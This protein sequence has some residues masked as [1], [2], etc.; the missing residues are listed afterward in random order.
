MQ[1]VQLEAPRMEDPELGH[2]LIGM[3]RK[4]PVYGGL[5][6]T[7][8]DP[9]V[10]GH[11]E[12]RTGAGA[13]APF[14]FVSLEYVFARARSILEMAHHG[15]LDDDVTREQV[16]LEFR[17]QR[18]LAEQG[19]HF[20]VLDFEVSVA[21]DRRRSITGPASATTSARIGGGPTDGAGSPEASRANAPGLAQ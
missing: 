10:I 3:I 5:G 1:V 9:V 15:L 21:N 17:S 4:W 13:G 8:E 20:D 11:P 16:V 6:Y 18:L 7:R 12:P 19:K 2:R 14:N